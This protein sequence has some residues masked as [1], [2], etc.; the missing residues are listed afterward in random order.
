MTKR[1]SDI[2]QP[3]RKAPGW[4][5]SDLPIYCTATLRV[6]QDDVDRFRERVTVDPIT[7]CWTMK[8]RAKWSRAAIDGIEHP[9]PY[10]VWRLFRNGLPPKFIEARC[11]TDGCLNP[12]HLHGA[13]HLCAKGLHVLSPE[14]LKPYSDGRMRPDT[15]APNGLSTFCTVLCSV[16]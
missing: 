4:R 5:R 11:D 6:D 9:L 3:H 16:L 8:S 1:S 2:R 15:P 12:Q 14:N 7:D 13:D 10:A